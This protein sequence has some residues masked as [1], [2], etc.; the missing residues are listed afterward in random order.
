MSSALS[1]AVGR[2]LEGSFAQP[3][4]VAAMLRNVTSNC[5]NFDIPVRAYRLFSSAINHGYGDIQK[6]LKSETT[7]PRLARDEAAA[8][9]DSS[10]S[11]AILDLRSFQSGPQA[12]VRA[13]ALIMSNLFGAYERDTLA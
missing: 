1:L 8:D 4:A 5:N 7:P 13:R 6:K 2:H 3:A 10:F 12:M 9:D 11:N